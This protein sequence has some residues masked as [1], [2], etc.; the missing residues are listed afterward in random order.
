MVCRKIARPGL[1]ARDGHCTDLDLS[2]I[3]AHHRSWRTVGGDRCRTAPSVRSPIL[4]LTRLIR[5]QSFELLV[6]A[7]GEFRA[8]LT[9]IALHRLWMQR[10]RE[11]LPR[12]AHS[13]NF[14]DRGVIFFLADAQQAPMHHT[15]M[16]IPPDR[17]MFYSQGAEHYQRSPVPCRWASMSL[18]IEDLAAAGQV[19]AGRDLAAPKVTALIRPPPGLMSRLSQLHAAAGHLAAMAPAFWRI[20]RSPK[21]SSKN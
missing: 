13:T 10:S 2:H 9:R 4:T 16:V 6:T 7:G 12:I 8:E 5:V 17:I 14:N 21:R 18:P 15:G 19:I 20:P 11:S 1:R 3:L